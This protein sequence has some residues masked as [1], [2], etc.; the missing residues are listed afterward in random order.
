MILE[1]NIGAE[2][3]VLDETSTGGLGS[4]VFRHP[5][6]TFALTPASRILL[7]AIV[8]NQLRLHGTGIDWG[9][10]IGC[11]AILAS[12]IPAVEKMYGLEISKENIKAA[13]WNAK[14]NGVDHKVSFL[15]SDSYVPFDANDRMMFESLRGS[16]DFIVSNPPFSE[17][18]DG[19]GFR[20]IVLD[21]A[22]SFLKPGGIVLLNISLQYGK[23]R[24]AS[25]HK[26]GSGFVHEG[27]AASSL[28]VPFHLD[29]PD[30]LE[31]LRLYACEEERGG[32]DY[33]FS[34]EGRDGDFVNARTAL[35]TY[36]YCGASPFMKWQTHMFRYLG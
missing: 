36:E 29:R 16:V 5:A 23:E 15:S 9:S 31:C 2:E 1:I 14:E 24:L 8:D 35:K 33:A 20:R 18:D 12:R 10:G 3:S 22:K 32:Y 19:F 6:G 21:G 26:P 7:T 27:I 28:W 25:L 11:Q 34:E 17:G 13:V 4:L 30:L